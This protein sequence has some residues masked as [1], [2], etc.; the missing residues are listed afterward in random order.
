MY[1]QRMKLSGSYKYRYKGYVMTHH[2][3]YS[4]YWAKFKG[5]RV[6]IL[7]LSIVHRLVVKTKKSIVRGI[8][9]LCYSHSD[10]NFS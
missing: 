4:H 5:F 1:V 9:V 3:C 10:N 8:P 6:L 7:I 2:A